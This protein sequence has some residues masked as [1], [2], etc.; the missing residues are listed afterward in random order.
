MNISSDLLKVA[1]KV[2]I[3]IDTT[4]FGPRQITAFRKAVRTGI[5]PNTSAPSMI[6]RQ[7][8]LNAGLPFIHFGKY[9]QFFWGNIPEGYLEFFDAVIAAVVATEMNSRHAGT[10]K[11]T[12]LVRAK[13][14]AQHRRSHGEY[15][16]TD[17]TT[18]M[19]MSNIKFPEYNVDLPTIFDLEITSALTN[20]WSNPCIS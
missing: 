11:N 20:S 8:R 19:V 17:D 10:A 9:G 1:A 6:A 14:A 5:I 16:Y 2:T 7:V 18:K 12:A 3:H 13:Q 4:K 15:H